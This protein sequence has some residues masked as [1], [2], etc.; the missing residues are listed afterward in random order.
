MKLTIYNPYL[1]KEEIKDVNEW[2]VLSMKAGKWFMIRYFE[3]REDAEFMKTELE[4][5]GH[6]RVRVTKSTSLKKEDRRHV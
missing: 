6:H 1:D 2:Y 4:L 5:N 3:R